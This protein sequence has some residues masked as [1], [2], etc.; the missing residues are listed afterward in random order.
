MAFIMIIANTDDVNSK[1]F[2]CKDKL[3]GEA[4]PSGQASSLAGSIDGP[5]SIEPGPRPLP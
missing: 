1:P 4:S 5:V 2:Y 3:R